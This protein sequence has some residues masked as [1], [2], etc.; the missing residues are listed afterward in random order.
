MR[1]AA[2]MCG[3]RHMSRELRIEKKK[4]IVNVTKNIEKGVTRM[5]VLLEKGVC[6]VGSKVV[7]S[8]VTT[9]E[10]ANGRRSL[11]GV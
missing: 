11:A 2:W 9:A 1:F 5:T 4:K 7:G 6:S 8:S 3:K 10:S